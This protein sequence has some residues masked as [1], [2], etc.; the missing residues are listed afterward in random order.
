MLG[1]L[2]PGKRQTPNGQVKGNTQGGVVH[3][4]RKKSGT[5]QA[6][7]EASGPLCGGDLGTQTQMRGQVLECEEQKMSAPGRGK[8]MAKAGSQG[9]GP[10]PM[11]E[12][13]GAKGQ[14]SSMRGR[15]PGF[16]HKCHKKAHEA[17]EQWDDMIPVIF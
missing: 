3:C 2:L 1:G 8:S 5:V 16:C 17:F 10:S 15:G 13:R 9:Q 12:A 7:G 11:E 4:T 14:V 6:I